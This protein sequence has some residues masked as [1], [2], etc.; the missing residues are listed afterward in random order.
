MA[1]GISI[2]RT[3]FTAAELRALA[4][5]ERD[6]PV[7]RR[8]LAIA[9]ALDG[10]D[11]QTAAH[12]CGMDRQTLRDWVHR[13]NDAGVAGLSNRTSPGRPPALDDAQM[14][15]L[16]EWVETGPNID[17]DGVVR[18]RCIDLKKKIKAEFNVDVHERT[19][20]KFLARLEYARLS[21]RPQHPKSDPEAQND[22][23]STSP[24]WSK[25]ASPRT[26][27]PSRSKFGSKMKPGSA[28]RGP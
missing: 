19:V 8:I 12:A 3:D 26:P 20:G 21:A 17:T 14:K 27:A 16:A 10:A 2:T 28:S 23:K 13:Y 4:A 11:R 24:A 6:A 22:F 18:W 25:K 1:F 15:T 5:K 7:V 9:M